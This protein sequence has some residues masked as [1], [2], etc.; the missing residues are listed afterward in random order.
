MNNLSTDNPVNHE[1]A[2]ESIKR[3]P[4]VVRNLWKIWKDILIPLLAVFGSIGA[5]FS[6]T[7]RFWPPT[8]DVLGVLPVYVRDYD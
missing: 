6:L 7:D 2:I 1:N 4:S 8:V 5:L 3:R